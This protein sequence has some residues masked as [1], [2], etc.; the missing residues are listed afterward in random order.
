MS[1][2]LEGRTPYSKVLQLKHSAPTFNWWLNTRELIDNCINCG[3]WE[4]HSTMACERWV[5]P[6]QCCLDIGANIGYF[7]VLLSHLVGPAGEVH[8]FEPMQE[9]FTVA[10]AH[11]RINS[12]SN[13]KVR[14]LALSDTCR[15]VNT[16][17]FNYSWHYDHSCEQQRCSYAETTLDSWLEQTGIHP[18]DFMKIDVDGYESKLLHGATR[19]LEQYKPVLLLEVCNY[20]LRDAAGPKESDDTY[21]KNS[22]ARA[23][24]EYLSDYDYEFLREEDD[25]PIPSIDALLTIVDLSRSSINVICTKKGYRVTQ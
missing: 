25:A 20:T 5:K 1:N 17:F 4:Y 9:A 23:L 11:C 8:G 2:F 7:T 21:I 12:L 15:E 19:T 6:G 18:P 13:A 14:Q 3:V 24:L 10:E 22:H 16:G